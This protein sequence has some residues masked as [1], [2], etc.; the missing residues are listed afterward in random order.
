M[1]LYNDYI[2]TLLDC[3]SLLPIEYKKRLEKNYRREWY[4]RS[5][6]SVQKRRVDH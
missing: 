4:K 2:Y 3:N 6:I 1:L 5:Q